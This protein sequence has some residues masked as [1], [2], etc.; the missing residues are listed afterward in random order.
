M[1][2]LHPYD[3]FAFLLV[4]L[5]SL[6]GCNVSKNVP[7]GKYLL[8]DNEFVLP[9]EVGFKEDNLR[10]IVRQNPNS[11]SLGIKWKLHIYNSID[12]VSR[13][14]VL[15]H[16]I[17]PMGQKRRDLNQRTLR[18]NERRKARQEKI[19]QRRMFRALNRGE[20]EYRHKNIKLK[21]T[22]NT[23]YFFREWLKYDIGEAPVIF[24]SL[25]MDVS[26]QQLQLYLKRK[27]FFNAN[28]RSETNYDK[29]K[30]TVVVSYIFEPGS[31]SIIDEVN[32][33]TDNARITNLFNSFMEEKRKDGLD[34][35]FDS[36]R[37]GR[38][39]N[40]FAEYV[41]DNAVYGFRSSYISFEVD[42]LR[43]ENTAGLDVR[44]AP[45]IIEVDG[46]QVLKPFAST[47]VR[48]VYF[49]I[50]DTMSYEGNFH[51]EQLRPRNINL[52]PTDLLPTFDTLRY[53]WY[54]GRNAQFRT[55]TFLYNGRLTIKP[56]LIEHQNFLEENNFYK[57][58]Y[59]DRSFNHLLQLDLFR[60][61][62]PR[63]VENED[64]T[65]DVHYH[66][67]PSKHQSFSF[68]PRATNSNG[69]LGV[70]SSVNYQH[71]NVFGGGEKLKLT[72]SGG[73][74][75]Q[76]SI[77]D[78]TE[79]GQS[80]T[81]A[82]RS[83]N[84]LEF[85]PTAELELPGLFPFKLARLSKR[86]LPKTSISL[87]YNYQTRDDFT[88]DLFQFNYSW[89]FYDTRKTQIFTVGLPIIGGFQFVSIDKS[90]AFEDRL[91]Q[92]NDLFLINAYSK[93]F[94]WKDIRIAYQYN[95]QE[96]RKGNLIFSYA[97]VFDLAGTLASL[98][99][100][101]QEVNAQG[102]KEIFGVRYSQFARWDHDFRFNH[103]LKG[104]RSINYRLQLGAGIPY[105]NNGP[106]LP[107][108]YSFFAGGSN[109]NRGFRARALGPGVY[110]YYLDT[111]RTA[112]EIG[113]IRIGGSVEYRFKLSG[114]F[115]GAVFSDF[116]NVW[117][118]NNDANRE[119]GQFTSDWYKQLSVAG[120]IG[121]RVDI[122]FL[123]FR[124]D[125]GIP[126]R[127][128]SLPSE[129]Q[130][131]WQSREAYRQEGF[132]VFGDEAER[133]LPNPFTPQVHIAIGYPF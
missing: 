89:K 119:F 72:F 23:R 128:P 86:Q 126:L 29:E 85:G 107:F 12:T 9:R 41:R 127:N 99:N 35:R 13:I 95:N 45:R 24:D 121:L 3:K 14:P 49:H 90:Q 22:A 19:N 114:M 111:N 123:V 17:R 68:E 57:G 40:E 100:Q 82:G 61:I 20:K 18:K 133:L 55:A 120:G 47:R 124:L 6:I 4:L 38:F 48:H 70:A 26:S 117:T 31:P 76:P 109:D 74:E 78:E 16:V 46:E 69:F 25:T 63:L 84:T 39:R 132:E 118:Y 5:F 42:T 56:E 106:N 54:D 1:F 113:D 87:A 21:D 52:A 11:S 115:K 7:E 101:N 105:G 10:N 59:V 102:F 79:S 122:D 92:Q 36:D 110:K 71:N 88:R 104:E 108:D 62:Q 77:F 28:V 37:L 27:G 75:S 125:V 130:W 131:I 2:T 33:R 98:L 50:N 80:I 116:G 53:D 65:I 67:L 81:N 43:H 112:T 66:L 64:N 60:S 51:K 8:D 103:L 15:K 83:F 94:I 96:V 44:I 91:N 93:Q 58:Y 34:N 73:F 97:N 129:S 30:R 32:L